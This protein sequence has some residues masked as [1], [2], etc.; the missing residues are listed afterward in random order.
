MNFLTRV[1]KGIFNTLTF[2]SK[3]QN[4]ASILIHKA[5]D[6][7]NSIVNIHDRVY[8]HSISF[9]HY[10]HEGREGVMVVVRIFPRILSSHLT[11]N[12]S[13]KF[14]DLKNIPEFPFQYAPLSRDDSIE[15]GLAEMT[16]IETYI[17]ASDSYSVTTL[18]DKIDYVLVRYN[19]SN[20]YTGLR[21][22]EI[23]YENNHLQVFVLFWNMDTDEFTNTTKTI[24]HLYRDTYENQLRNAT[25]YMSRKLSPECNVMTIQKEMMEF[26]FI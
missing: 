16:L 5:V 23:R 2:R 19:W 22:F 21:I 6:E 4:V 7:Y 12:L 20:R 11:A 3:S 14:H 8:I 1:G 15:T 9:N 25:E 17:S 10:Y 26:T 18:L 13:S 24:G